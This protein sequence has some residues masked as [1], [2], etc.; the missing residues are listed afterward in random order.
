L[1]RFFHQKIKN[2][3]IALEG[4]KGTGKSSIFQELHRYVQNKKIHYSFFPITAPILADRSIEVVYQ[5]KAGLESNDH[6]LEHLFAARA[7]WHQERV[8]TRG[9]VILGDRSLLTS[10]VTRWHKWKDPYYTIKRVDTMYKEIM[11]P[12]V[13]IWLEGDPVNSQLNIS[14]RPSKATGLKDE[15]LPRLMEAAD[16]YSELLDEGLYRRRSGKV[17]V[18]KICANASVSDLSKEIISVI[19]FYK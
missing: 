8:D 5:K 18:V 11:R 9:G 10:Y 7:L 19:K 16:I 17:Q 15:C 1:K 6:F 13:V 12:D 14:R 4:I 2:M 3:Y